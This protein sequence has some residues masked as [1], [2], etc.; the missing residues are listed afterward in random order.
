LFL[1]VTSECFT[2]TFP[3]SPTELPPLSDPL[4]IF[5]RW[6]RYDE[7]FHRNKRYGGSS[8]SSEIK[9]FLYIGV[10]SFQVLEWVVLFVCYIVDQYRLKFVIEVG[11]I[12]LLVILSTITIYVCHSCDWSRWRIKS[13]STHL[14]CLYLFSF[15]LG[16]NSTVYCQNMQSF[17][18][19]F[20]YILY[21][22]FDFG[23]VP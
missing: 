22:F 14:V 11:H 21:K 12:S 17:Y 5:L 4:T 20:S 16:D 13:S 15:S 7:M 19:Y 23:T 1:L 10:W 2:P 18:S 9:S 8:I 3:S 6:H